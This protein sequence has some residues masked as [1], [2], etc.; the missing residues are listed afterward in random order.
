[1]VLKYHEAGG[2]ACR[3]LQ[4]LKLMRTRLTRSTAQRLLPKQIANKQT[5]QTYFRCMLRNDDIFEKLLEVKFL[6][7]AERVS[8]LRF[9][10]IIPK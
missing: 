2:T 1:M 3:R 8:P 6:P 4:V 5:K 9:L 7:R 10:Q